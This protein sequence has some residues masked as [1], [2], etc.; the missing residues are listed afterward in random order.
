MEALGIFPAAAELAAFRGMG[1][2]EWPGPKI[3]TQ[4]EMTPVGLA[5]WNVAGLYWRDP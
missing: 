2:R 1:D 4:A 3:V 5:M